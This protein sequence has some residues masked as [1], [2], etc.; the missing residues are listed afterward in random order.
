MR[1]LSI[2]DKFIEAT[3]PQIGVHFDVHVTQVERPNVVFIQ[4]LFDSD[5]GDEGYANDDDETEESAREQHDQFQ[6]IAML[7]N[8]EGFFDDA[9]LLDNIVPGNLYFLL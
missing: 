9:S 3:L 2:M 4:R 8:S 1:S 5:D 7:I 6:R